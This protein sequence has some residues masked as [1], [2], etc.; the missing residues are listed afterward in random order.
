MYGESGNDDIYGGH[1]IDFGQDT[2]DEL[3]SGGPDQDAILGDNGQIVR[4]RVGLTSEFPWVNG[5]VW[6]NYTDPFDAEVVRDIR[7]YDDVD[8]IGVREKL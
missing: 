7:R 3:L 1:N 2:G 6:L 5:M 4:Q 8:E